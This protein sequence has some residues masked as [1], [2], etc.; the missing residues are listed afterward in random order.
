MQEQRGAKEMLEVGME[1]EWE[2][3][4]VCLYEKTGGATAGTASMYE[5]GKEMGLDRPTAQ[6]VAEHLMS[7]GFVEVRTLSGGVG[8]TPD[9]VE[10]GASLGGG[11]GSVDPVLSNGPVLQDRELEAVEALLS[12]LK[13]ATADL[14]LPFDPLAEWVADVRTLEAQLQSPRPKTAVMR[15]GFASLAAAA[16]VAG[17]KEFQDRIIHLIGWD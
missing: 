15:A 3:F 2:Q 8:L 10:K 17:K 6:N 11:Q 1:S 5:I 12:D 4:L 9:G 16:G 7:Q 14:G 13:G